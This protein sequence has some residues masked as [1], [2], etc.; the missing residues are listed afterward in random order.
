M[1]DSSQSR[2]Q[3]PNHLGPYLQHPPVA[4]IEKILSQ[5][6]DDFH[7]ALGGHLQLEETPRQHLFT[8][9]LYISETTSVSARLSASWAL[10]LPAMSLIRDRYEQTVRLSWLARQPDHAEMVKYI[11]SYYA[12][13]NKIFRNLTSSQREELENSGVTIEDWMVDIPTK[14]QKGYLERWN[15]LPL[16]DMADKRDKLQPPSSTALDRQ[17]LGDLYAPIYQQFS[18]VTHFDAYALNMI[19]LH[20]TPSDQLVL[21]PDPSWPAVLFMY[22]ALFSLIQCHESLLAFYDIDCANKFDD[23]FRR[24][25]EASKRLTGG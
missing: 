3:V 8:R 1:A 22:D 6:F 9:L 25:H 11:G 7:E 18:S 19:G 17:T 16:S 5:C 10:S 13:A 23:L 21:A 24:W 20:K 2:A 12:K 15:S 14:K 4:E